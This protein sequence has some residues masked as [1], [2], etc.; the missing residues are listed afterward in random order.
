MVSGCASISE[1][2]EIAERV[3]QTKEYNYPYKEVFSACGSSLKDLQ[4]QIRE[5]NYEEGYISAYVAHSKSM[6]LVEKKMG[7]KQL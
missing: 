5:S 3:G 2:R 7:E 4:F 1:Q 6:V